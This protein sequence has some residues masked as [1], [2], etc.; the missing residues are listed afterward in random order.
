MC[1]FYSEFEGKTGRG[2]PEA[3]P[4]TTDPIVAFFAVA[5]ALRTDRYRGRRVQAMSDYVPRHFTLY[6]QLK[7]NVQF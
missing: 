5:A 4:K 3:Y 1:A 2:L 7:N 6:N